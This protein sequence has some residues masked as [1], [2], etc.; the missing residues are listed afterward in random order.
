MNSH[1]K[2]ANS[3]AASQLN[4]IQRNKNRM[5]KETQSFKSGTLKELFKAAEYEPEFILEPFMRQGEATLIY[6]ASGLGKSFYAAGLA[7]AIA[8]GGEFIGY[9]AP[10]PRKVKY[11]DGE[12]S[13]YDL[14]LRVKSAINNKTDMNALYA[15]LSITSREAHT[16]EH[17]SFPDISDKVF[18]S[19]IVRELIEEE[20]EVVIFDNFST[21]ALSLE[22]ENAAGGFNGTLELMLAL[23]AVGILPILVH[24]STK[25]GGTYRGTSKM[26]AVY[27]NII[28]LH[29]DKE[30]DPKKGCGFSIVFDKNRSFHSNLTEV[31]AVQYLKDEGCWVDVESSV[32]KIQVIVDALQSL[33]YVTQNEMAEGLG[34]GSS[35]VSKWVNRAY[36]SGDLTE[37]ELTRLFNLAQA[38]RDREMLEIEGEESDF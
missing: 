14:S 10:K 30:I 20:I 27:S 16:D 35:T 2:A 22:D 26:E 18:K 32:S 12:M 1:E 4:K 28:G 15:N 37:K 8:S 31:R 29:R 11:I 36:A 3:Y 24:H 17:T 38:E 34:W 13:V 19:K 25:A 9:S 21:L 23:K 7:V 33:K 5:M 6:A